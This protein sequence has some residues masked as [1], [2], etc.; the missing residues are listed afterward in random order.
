MKR[1]QYSVITGVSFLGAGTI[2]RCSAN[3]GVQRITTA[4]SLLG[5]VKTA[6][7]ANTITFDPKTH[8]VWIAYAD[9][10]HSYVRRL[11]AQ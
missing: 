4:A 9:K 6:P 1:V 7:G 8:A 11:A 10:E 3:D 2:I 5:N